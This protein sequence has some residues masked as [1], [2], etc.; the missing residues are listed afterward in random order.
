MLAFL[1]EGD[2][3]LAD[4]AIEEPASPEPA[5]AAR[6]RLPAPAAVDGVPAPAAPGA[7]LLAARGRE[8]DRRNQNVDRKQRA[9]A[10]ASLVAIADIASPSLQREVSAVFGFDRTDGAGAGSKEGSALLMDPENVVVSDRRRTLGRFR[11]RAL[12]GY[13]GGCRERCA[14]FVAG[15][16]VAICSTLCDDA[17][18]WC[19]LPSENIPATL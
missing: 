17:S 13:A 18:M 2:G 1:W 8:T 11:K 6:A 19:R 4:E 3:A 9:A 5:A 12:V 7:G 16:D 14:G 10:E 15:A